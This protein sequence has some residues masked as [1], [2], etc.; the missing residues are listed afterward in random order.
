[1]R[2]AN[3]ATC[4]GICKFSGESPTQNKIL[5]SPFFFTHTAVDNGVMKPFGNDFK[6]QA[7]ALKVFIALVTIG[8]G[9]EN[10]QKPLEQVA[11]VCCPGIDIYIFWIF[12]R[13]SRNKFLC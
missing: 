3:A 1:V 4:T 7:K 11:Y 12:N 9:R 5:L 2:A 10:S 6:G 8:D 13:L